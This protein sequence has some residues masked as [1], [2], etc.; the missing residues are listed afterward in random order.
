MVVTVEG[1]RGRRWA[2]NRESVVEVGRRRVG[3]QLRHFLA[4]G[5]QGIVRERRGDTFEFAVPSVWPS[6]QRAS[7]LLAHL[8]VGPALV[9]GLAFAHPG[10][11]RRRQAARKHGVMI[12]HDEARLANAQQKLQGFSREGA[13]RDRIAQMDKEVVPLLLNC[14]ERRLQGWQICVYIGQHCEFHC[15][16]LRDGLV[17][18][19]R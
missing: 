16:C 8:R 2:G 14:A 3:H 19:Q 4:R 10:R 13:C 15:F 5:I 6:G 12:A 11:R 17:G 9:F 7:K 1:E 18:V